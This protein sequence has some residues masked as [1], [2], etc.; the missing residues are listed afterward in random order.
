MCTISINTVGKAK[1][2]YCFKLFSHRHC[3]TTQNTRIFSDTAVR[4]S[5]MS[6]K[7]IEYNTGVL[8]SP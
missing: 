6:L 2:L 7:F 4:I 5:N 8:I 3:V 1:K